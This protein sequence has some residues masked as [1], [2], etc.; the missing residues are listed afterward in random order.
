MA[1]F[2]ARPHLFEA[3]SRKTYR[4]HADSLGLQLDMPLHDI[5]K[6]GQQFRPAR[7]T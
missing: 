4:R 7:W 2:H 5:P 1:L 3:D 6:V